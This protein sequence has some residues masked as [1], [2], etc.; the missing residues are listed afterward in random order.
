MNE[1]AIKLTPEVV[2]TLNGLCGQSTLSA[3]ITRLQNAEEALQKVAYN[4]MTGELDYLFRFAYD[5]K[6]M[7]EE[8][9]TLEKTLGYEPDRD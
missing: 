5:L 8:L 3:N 6:Q 7:R 9:E 2:Q 4:E 1:N